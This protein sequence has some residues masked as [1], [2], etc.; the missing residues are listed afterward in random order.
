MVPIHNFWSVTVKSLIT[1]S[2]RSITRR[3]IDPGIFALLS[4]EHVTGHTEIVI[5]FNKYFVS[6]QWNRL[7]VIKSIKKAISM[8]LNLLEVFDKSKKFRLLI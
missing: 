6:A 3:K 1:I 4:I 5:I 2:S 8:M 7:N